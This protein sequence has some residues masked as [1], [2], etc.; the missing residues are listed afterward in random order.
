MR[1]AVI[2]TGIMGSGM[3]GS[4][5]REGHEVVVWNRSAD[6]ARALV[7][8]GISAA[9]TVADAVTGAD[10]VVTVLFDTDAVLGVTPEIAGALGPD[11]VWVQSSTV[12][13]D[14]ARRIAE[15]AGGRILDAPVIGTRKPAAD[16]TLVVLVSGPEALVDRARP[17]FDA[18]GSRTV[19]A[20][21]TV[22]Q[23]SALKL[24]VNSWIGLLTSGVAQSLAF[25][26]SLGL[27]PSLFLDAIKGAPVDSA[28]AHAKG[29]AM[30]KRDW[31][32]SFAVDGVRKDV[33]LMIDAARGTDF[34]TGLL[35]AVLAT[36]DD[37]AAQGHGGDDMAAVR[38][39]FPRA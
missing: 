36:F 33:G 39:A 13:P 30:L 35:E 17:V 31:T 19:L 34:P 7:G 12:G 4:L 18:I 9:D 6:K 27:D 24:V 10:A 3:A 14:G 21:D 22:G 11:A 15:Q 25:A 37:A 1:V 26:E 2:G 28:Y 8:G 20:G 5:A 32:T 16:G 38:T 29:G 23:A